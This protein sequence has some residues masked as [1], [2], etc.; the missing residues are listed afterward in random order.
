MTFYRKNKRE[1]NEDER[2]EI[3]DFTDFYLTLENE[4]FYV[5][6]AQS[7]NQFVGYIC[8]VYLPKITRV[9]SKGYLYIDEIWIK[10]NYR[11]KGIA[12]ALM[13][14]ADEL[15]KEINTLGLRLYVS[16]DNSEAI[17]LY[18]KCGYEKKFG[19]SLFMEKE[20]K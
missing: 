19:E 3:Q 1:K 13:K 17:S 14:K 18:K 6:A 12:N 5:F 15:S 11:G 4:N 7:N 9:N 2:K 16:A 20:L 10:P 8:T